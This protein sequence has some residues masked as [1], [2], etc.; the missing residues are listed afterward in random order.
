[1]K[2][3]EV[4]Y[5]PQ[6]LKTLLSVSRLVLKDSTMGSTQDKIIIKKNGVSM[7]L[8]AR[9]YQNKSMVFYLKAKRYAPEVKE[10]LTN[11]PEKKMTPVMKN[12]NGVR[13]WSYQVRWASTWYI[14]TNI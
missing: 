2:L 13:S 1:M 7:N 4:L 10:A 5:M 6:A 8:D 11:I 12:K 3:T 14:G 9:R